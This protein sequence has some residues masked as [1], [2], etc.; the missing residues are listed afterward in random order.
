MSKKEQTRKPKQY[1]TMHLRPWK[2]SAQCS[3]KS[4]AGL[5]RSREKLTRRFWSPKL[6]PIMKNVSSKRRKIRQFG[7]NTD[8]RRRLSQR[9]GLHHRT[10][11]ADGIERADQGKL[12]SR[13][14][15]RHTDRATP[16]RSFCKHGPQRT[17]PAAEFHESVQSHWTSRDLRPLRLYA[18]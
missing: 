17:K 7:P 13:R 16:S 15:L 10:P 9:G 5:L 2:A 18:G 3:L 14:S 8:A 6:T 12:F 11:R 1:L 4:T